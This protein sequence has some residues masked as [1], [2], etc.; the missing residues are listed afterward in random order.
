MA[1]FGITRPSIT[2]FYFSDRTFKFFSSNRFI[3]ILLLGSTNYSLP[4]IDGQSVFLFVNTFQ[5]VIGAW[6]VLDVMCMCN[7]YFYF[8]TFFSCYKLDLHLQCSV[9]CSN[10]EAK[11]E[12]ERKIC[13]DTFTR[14]TWMVKSRLSHF[15]CLWSFPYFHASLMV[16]IPFLASICCSIYVALIT[17]TIITQYT[18]S[19]PIFALNLRCKHKD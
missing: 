1:L 17:N 15:D 12:E 16:G 7:F 4:T 10:S 14:H 3:Q 5:P 19:L 6:I 8:T 2:I 13:R 18:Q 11:R 9:T